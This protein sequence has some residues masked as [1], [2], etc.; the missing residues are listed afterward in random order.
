MMVPLAA[1]GVG[2]AFYVMAETKQVQCLKEHRTSKTTSKN[3][4]RREKIQRYEHLEIEQGDQSKCRRSAYDGPLEREPDRLG[5]LIH[6]VD[7]PTQYSRQA[8]IESVP[9]AQYCIIGRQTSATP[10]V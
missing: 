5:L 7:C 10:S 9:R 8:G 6:L 1:M 2:D 4:L 3:S